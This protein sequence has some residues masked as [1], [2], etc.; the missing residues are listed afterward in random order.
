[1]GVSEIDNEVK[2]AVKIRG[3]MRK[4]RVR[5]VRVVTQ[6]VMGGNYQ[7]LVSRIN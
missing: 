5:K 6:R 4:F 7:R 2:V 3:S 1:M